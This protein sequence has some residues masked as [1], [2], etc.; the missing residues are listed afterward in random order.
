MEGGKKMTLFNSAWTSFK[1]NIMVNLFSILQLTVIFGIIFFMISSALIRYSYY[2]PFK[3]YFQ[4]NGV[5]VNFSDT[6]M[7]D[8]GDLTTLKNNEYFLNMFENTDKIISCH[9]PFIVPKKENAGWTPVSYDDEI[10]EN[11]RPEL[12][13]GRWLKITNDK[14]CVEAVISEN[15][16][17]WN[18]GDTIDAI[19]LNYEESVM[20]ETDIP[21][22]IKIVGKLKEGTKIIGGNSIYSKNPSINDFYYPYS[23]KI[24]QTPLML[25]SYSALNNIKIKK[26]DNNRP[27]VYQGEYSSMIL[28]FKNQIDSQVF[29][30]IEK[31]ISEKSY[32][33]IGLIANLKDFNKNSKEYITEQAKALFPIMV[34]ILIMVLISSISVSAISTRRKLKD[35]AIFYINGL[36]WN[37]CS[38]IN[39][40]ESLIISVISIILSVVTIL[41]IQLTPLAESVKIIWSIY[42]F[43]ACLAI[44]LL[45]ILI[46]MLMPFI[47]I[48]HNTPKEILTR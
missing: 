12:S 15:K 33:S 38:L 39:L 23:F 24:E 34:I 30:E 35:Y 18:V 44:M 41:V 10:I 3:E 7:D 43:L 17:N 29:D 31:K 28:T 19:C 5:Y 20:N 13:E 22:K 1:N 11:Y 37:Q 14:D 46:S 9:H 32:Y 47:I 45:Y 48:K 21:I 36:Q 2:A 40:Y 6:V 25:F 8:T 26:L 16:N 27:N 4:A 42:G